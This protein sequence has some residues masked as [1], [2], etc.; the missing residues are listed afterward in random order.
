[1]IK[2]EGNSL[3]WYFLATLLSWLW[4]S[5]WKCRNVIM[6]HT[7]AK[8]WLL[9]AKDWRTLNI[10]MVW[11]KGE[12]KKRERGLR[13]RTLRV[14]WDFGTLACRGSAH[15]MGG[16]KGEGRASRGQ[17]K[18]GQLSWV[19][20]TSAAHLGLT[21]MSLQRPG[22]WWI[23]WCIP[24]GR[25]CRQPRCS[26][27]SKTTELRM[28]VVVLR[29]AYIGVTWVNLFKSRFLSIILIKSYVETGDSL[30]C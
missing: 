26:V 2:N 6:Q 27:L 19:I 8:A 4:N 1:M 22:I 14:T 30:H 18:C 20:Q 16:E 17:R 29:L 23:Y 7:A 12:L 21:L 11:E 28:E 9:V 24:V 15:V 25:G 13:K 5:L 3:S 10:R